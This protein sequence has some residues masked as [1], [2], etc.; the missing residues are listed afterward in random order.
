MTKKEKREFS[1]N[2]KKI[3]LD[4]WNKIKEKRAEIWLNQEKLA[5]KI[6]M[7]RSYISMIERWEANITYLKLKRIEEVLNLKF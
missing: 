4:I 1:E 3:L 7:D 2:E 5:L 6:W